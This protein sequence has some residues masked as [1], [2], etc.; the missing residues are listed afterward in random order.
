VIQADIAF[1]RVGRWHADL[2]VANDSVPADGTQVTLTFTNGAYS[3]T[4]TVHRGGAPFGTG[5]IRVV[6]GADG[7]GE[8][9]DPKGYRGCAVSLPLGDICRDAGETLSSQSDGA[10]LNQQI[11]AWTRLGVLAGE[12]LA[13]LLET[14]PTSW[15]FLSDGSLWV[16]QEQWTANVSAWEVIQDLPIQGMQVLFSETP[17]IMPG[18]TLAGRQV[19]Y[20][21]HDF[22]EDSIRTSVWYTDPGQS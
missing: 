21:R 10:I 14:F 15:R 16:G 5:M 9:L 6:G 22:G 4:G 8:A 3:W 11:S 1:P 17:D 13:S 2:L 18:Q 19:D 20:V 12:A 7:F